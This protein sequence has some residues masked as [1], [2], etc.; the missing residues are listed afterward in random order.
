[1]LLWYN[2]ID[3]IQCCQ[4]RKYTRISDIPSGLLSTKIYKQSWNNILFDYLVTVYCFSK[5][6][7]LLL[8]CI[9][10]FYSLINIIKIEFYSETILLFHSY[11]LFLFGLIIMI[12]IYRIHLVVIL[13]LRYYKTDL[14]MCHRE[15]K[16][17]GIITM[18][19]VYVFVGNK[20][21]L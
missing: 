15:Q 8:S 4:G 7:T 3:L 9:L 6:V 12:K 10:V 1:M 17:A 13:Y 20:N 2:K 18:P 14:T 5:T 19:S 21:I 16:Y 11:N